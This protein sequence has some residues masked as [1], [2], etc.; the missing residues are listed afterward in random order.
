MI[1]KKC[2]KSSKGWKPA[3]PVY[4]VFSKGWKISVWFFQGLEEMFPTLG[5]SRGELD[6]NFVEALAPGVM[7][8]VC[9]GACGDV[10]C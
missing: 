10:V 5:N 2:L 3:M 8:G 9:E 7:R 4:L 1:G 6:I